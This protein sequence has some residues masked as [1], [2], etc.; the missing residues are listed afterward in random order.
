[1]TDEELDAAVADTLIPV[2]MGALSALQEAAQMYLDILKQ[3]V[4]PEFEGQLTEALRAH[5]SACE[6]ISHAYRLATAQL[7]R[8]RLKARGAHLH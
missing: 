2:P 7:E 4:A 8:A 1:M 3:G 6:E 5:N